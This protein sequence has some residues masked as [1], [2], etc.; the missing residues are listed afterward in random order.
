[1]T[2]LQ[3]AMLVAILGLLVIG[4]DNELLAQTARLPPP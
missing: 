4:L 3:I 2:K 1:M